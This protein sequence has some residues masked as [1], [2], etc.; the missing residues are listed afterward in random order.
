M[1]ERLLR[2]DFEADQ[3]EIDHLESEDSDVGSKY[4]RLSFRGCTEQE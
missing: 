2:N 1:L 3:S 4:L